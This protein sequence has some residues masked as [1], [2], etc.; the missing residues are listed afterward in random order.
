MQIYE[1]F[2]LFQN[3]TETKCG[4]KRKFSICV[5]Y[6]SVNQMNIILRFDKSFPKSIFLFI[7]Y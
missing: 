3:K 1:C 4:I 7:L 5:I 6:I 2:L